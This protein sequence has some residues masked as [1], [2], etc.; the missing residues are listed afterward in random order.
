[1]ADKIKAFFK[2]KKVEAKFKMAGSGQKLGNQSSQPRSQSGP[3]SRPVERQ[4]PSQSSQQAGA[5]ALNRLNQEPEQDFQRKR[6]AARIKEQARRELEQ[7]QQQQQ[8]ID[9]MKDVY[10]DKEPEEVEGPAQLEGVYYKCPMVGEEVYTKDVMKEKIKEFL[11]S[12]LEEETALT[13]ALI[14]HTC[15]SPRE[16]VSVCVDTICKYIDNILKNPTEEKFRKIRHSNKAFQERVASL[17]GANDFLRGCGFEVKN[18]AGP[19]GAEE[20]F[21]VFPP[22]GDV[23]NLAAMKDCLLSAEPIKAELDRDT[24]VLSPSS[25]PPPPPVL[26]PSFFSITKEEVKREQQLK[27]E[28]V[29]RENMLRTKAMREKEEMKSRRKYRFCLIRVRFPDNYIIQGTF[30][31]YEPLSAVLEWV[32]DCLETPLP[33]QL[34]DSA[35]GGRLEE[36]DETLIQTG[37]V[38]TAVMVFSWD[39][40]IAKEVAASGVKPAFLKAD[41]LRS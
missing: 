27:S 9:R 26:P 30:A 3:Q 33:F 37:L 12:Q 21:W 41:L 35:T 22:T 13:A 19:D 39:E 20:K 7:E 16:K 2:K 25:G 8:E 17:E 11:Y 31:V 38:P 18:L 32:T 40:E 36:T 6:Q 5:A 23:D 24:K 10:G 15:N 4:H 1:M 28:I 14:I 29:E 34:T